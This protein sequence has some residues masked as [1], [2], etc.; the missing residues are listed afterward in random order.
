V[1]L[2]PWVVFGHVF[3]VIIA[4]GAHGVSAYAIFGVKA[5]RDRTRLAAILEL[6]ASS[7][8]VAGIFILVAVVLGIV[9]SVMAGH[10]SRFWPWAAIIVT[11]IV[12]GLMTPL[13]GQPLAGV[14]KALGMP[15]AGSKPSDPAPI[16]GTDA[17]LGAAI[18]RVRPELPAAVGIVGLAVLIWLMEAKPF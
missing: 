14:R 13:A 6:S 1:D 18:A 12:I 15:G 4:L 17:E 10:F 7:L 9:A 11:V 5:E 8:L 2:Y 16:P 3:T